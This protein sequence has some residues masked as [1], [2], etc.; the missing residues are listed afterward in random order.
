M[1]VDREEVEIIRSNTIRIRMGFK[2]VRAKSSNRS[3][4]F[5]QKD[6]RE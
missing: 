4:Y 3:L 6:T 2:Q 5:N 1:V